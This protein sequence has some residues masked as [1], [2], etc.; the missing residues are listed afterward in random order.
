MGPGDRNKEGKRIPIDV[1][2]EDLVL[3]GKYSGTEFKIGQEKYLVLK[4]ADVLA[5]VEQ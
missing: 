4:E 1:T 2:L 5:I 3:F